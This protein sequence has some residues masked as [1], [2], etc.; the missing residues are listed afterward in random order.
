MSST[1]IRRRRWATTAVAAVAGLFLLTACNP[2]QKS[3]MQVGQQSGTASTYDGPP[4]AWIEVSATGGSGFDIRFQAVI[5]L[6]GFGERSCRDEA[7]GAVE[8]C[9]FIQEVVLTDW[10]P[11]AAGFRSTISPH[12][13]DR[14]IFL[15]ECSQGGSIV[16]CP[17][18]MRATLRA[19]DDDGDLVGDLN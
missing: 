10:Y 6:N 14:P 11:V 4:G 15:F 17:D 5:F 1:P 9:E 7:T 2:I 18:S 19:V 8:P 3:L 12:D 13:G 16:I